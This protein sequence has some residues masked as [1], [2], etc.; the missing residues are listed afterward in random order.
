MSNVVVWALVTGFITGAVWVG[1]L[2]L[3][4]QRRLPP[5][6]PGLREDLER[7]LHELGSM[8]ARLA[9]VEERLD[10]A[11]RLLIKQRDEERLAPPGGS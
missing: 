10:F 2:A 1:I 8:E 3:R 7:R 9:E 5:G 6:Q 11:E 4:R